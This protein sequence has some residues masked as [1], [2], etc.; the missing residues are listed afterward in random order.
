MND[1]AKKMGATN[2]YKIMARMLDAEVQG[3]KFR[4][5]G[6]KTTEKTPAS[7]GAGSKQKSKSEYNKSG[8][9]GA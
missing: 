6:I 9:K 3:R 5:E 4:F 2:P 1:E 8:G 7:G